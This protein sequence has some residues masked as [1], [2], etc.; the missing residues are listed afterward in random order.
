MGAEDDLRISVAAEGDQVR[1]TAEGNLDVYTADLLR[2]CLDDHVRG[3]AAVVEIHLVHVGVIDSAGLGALVYGYKMMRE[4]GKEL[5][6]LGDEK[7]VERLLHRTCLDRV[8]PM[9]R[10]PTTG[11]AAS[12]RACGAGR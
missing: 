12:G 11:P 9:T 3:D 4:R 2:R 1:I 8:L 7:V 5:K 10:P 6:L